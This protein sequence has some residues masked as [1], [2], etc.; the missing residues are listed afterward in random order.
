MFNALEYIAANGDI[1]HAD[2][3]GV[4]LLDVM[5]DNFKN[6]HK[7]RTSMFTT[8]ILAKIDNHEIVL[9]YNSQYHAG[10]N[11]AKRIKL[12]K[13][14]YM[15]DALS[16]NILSSDKTTLCH[17]LAHA[18][19]K[20]DDLKAIY[21]KSCHYVMECFSAVYKHDDITRTMSPVKRLAHHQAY[22]KPL[23][24]EV[25]MHHLITTL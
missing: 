16:R 18:Y 14:I 3:S 19:R 7:K 4:K 21:P 12:S 10:E 24:Q 9:F 17:Y 8:A 6:P 22:S 20:F 11:M 23:M 13:P 1:I 25:K 15:C 2:D 5:K